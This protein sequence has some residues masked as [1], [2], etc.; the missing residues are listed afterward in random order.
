M[1]TSSS[2]AYLSNLETVRKLSISAAVVKALVF[3]EAFV[4]LSPPQRKQSH[5]IGHVPRALAKI[6]VPANQISRNLSA[7]KLLI[8]L[9]LCL[10]VHL[11]SLFS[12]KLSS[13]STKKVGYP[14]WRCLKRGE[15][16]KHFLNDQ[17]N[18]P[19][20]SVVSVPSEQSVLYLSQSEEANSETPR[21]I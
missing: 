1:E 15:I 2:H 17:S 14:L 16:A 7:K 12:V 19:L 18:K 6:F 21:M 3:G 9:R 8:S 10:V 13:E 11:V 20:C 4:E 5:L